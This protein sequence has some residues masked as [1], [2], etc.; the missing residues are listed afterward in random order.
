M[1]K[2]IYNVIHNILIKGKAHVCGEPETVYVPVVCYNSCAVISTKQQDSHL[3]SFFTSFLLKEKL[4]KGC[5][6]NRNNICSSRKEWTVV[7]GIER[8]SLCLAISNST[9]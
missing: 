6:K 8:G 7:L 1:G 2:E 3:K 4:I 5:D 9:P